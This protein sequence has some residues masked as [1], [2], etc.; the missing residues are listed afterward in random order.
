M[1]D[2]IVALPCFHKIVE[3]FPNSERIALTNFPESG[4]AAPLESI[5]KNGGFIHRCIE[6]PLGTRSPAMLGKIVRELRSTGAD[7]LIYLGTSRGLISAFRDW[8]FFRYCGFSRVIGIPT[9]RDMEQVRRDP[10]SGKEEY[11]ASR[12]ARCILELGPISMNSPEVWDLRLTV[13]EHQVAEE[14]LGPLQKKALIAVNTGGKVPMKDWGEANWTTLLSQVSGVLPAAAVI[15]VGSSDDYDRASRLAVAW[16]RASVNLCGQISP[17]ETAA[18]L[19]RATIFIGHDSGPMH[20]AASVQTPCVALFGSYN[21]PRKW[22]P[23][24]S[25]HRIIHNLNGILNITP[26]EV[27][28]EVRELFDLSLA[29]KGVFGQIVPTSSPSS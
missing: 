1:G 5:L 6:Y 21:K 22:H 20:F 18:V 19:G 15:F 16:G 7:T 26:D 12:L 4:K 29:R 8:L 13:E 2:T 17:R 28:R 24:G 25:Q 27:A 23:Y 11:E 3:A 14:I 10:V 9:S